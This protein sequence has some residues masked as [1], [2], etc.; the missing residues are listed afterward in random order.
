MQ[1]RAVRD[2]ST[3]S[4]LQPRVA[5][6][7]EPAPAVDAAAKPAAAAAALAA[8]VAATAIATALA[9]A[10]LAAALATAAIAAAA[11]PAVR[12]PAR[13]HRPH[14]PRWLPSLQLSSILM[15]L[16]SLPSACRVRPA[17][18]DKYMLPAP[19]EGLARTGVQVKL[20]RCY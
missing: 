19:G 4:L 18:F 11:K 8:F 14:P 1:P 6:A 12:S 2:A 10:A 9:T 7:S 13:P 15:P 20:P 3:R 16:P 5:G 17:V